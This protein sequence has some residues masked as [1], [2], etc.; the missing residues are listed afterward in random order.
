MRDIRLPVART[1]VRL[2]WLFAALAF[3]G[4][5]VV[6][7]VAI[8]QDSSTTNLAGNTGSQRLF[9]TLGSGDRIRVVVFG[10]EDLSGEF[11]VDGS[12]FISFPLIGEVKVQEMTLRS[13]EEAITDKLKPDYLRNPRVSVEV[14]N[15]RPF[16]IL[17]EVKSPGSYPY[18]SGMTVLNAV[19]LAGGYTYRARENRLLIQR[20]NRPDGE[21]EEANHSTAVLPGDIIEVPERFF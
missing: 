6:S 15:Y 7:T 14:L 3:V 4:W 8:A 19:A 1:G 5:A 20:A 2:T 11:E 17:G 13:A 9:Y 12:G 10:H 18:V 16:Y 21:Q